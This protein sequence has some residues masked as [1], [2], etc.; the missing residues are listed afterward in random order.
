MTTDA[1]ETRLARLERRNR[2]LYAALGLTV[3]ALA[4]S[5]AQQRRAPLKLAS[6]D[7]VS[8]VLL[9]HDRLV[10][11]RGGKQVVGLVA[12]ADVTAVLL[13]H[14][15]QPTQVLLSPEALGF[16]SGE[17]DLVTLLARGEGQ[18]RGLLL[19]DDGGNARAG[20]M[21]STAGAPTLHA[22]GE[23]SDV[24][25]ALSVSSDGIARVSATRGRGKLA[26]VLR[27]GDDWAGASAIDGAREATLRLDANGPRLFLLGAGG[28][29]LEHAPPL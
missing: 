5:F 16:R 15:E 3:L 26:A 29:A 2:I 19:R 22:A 28:R 13:S 18:N 7:G 20:V 4:L 1:L 27:A 25:A 9:Q 11:T 12:A 23:T 17:R 24:Q 6:D 21:L 14:P 10:F 8:E